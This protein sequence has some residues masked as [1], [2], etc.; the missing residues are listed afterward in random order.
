MTNGP[1]Q[2]TPFRILLVED[3]PADVDLTREALE[4]CRVAVEMTD[5]D[6]GHDALQFL[7]REGKYSGATM[8]D[9]ILLDLNLPGKNGRDVL[10][11]IG[12]D[13]QLRAIPVVILTSS[14]A[15]EDI[16]KAYD[17]GANCYIS[18]PVD[19]GE[20]QKIVEAIESFWLTLVKLPGKNCS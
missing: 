17:L 2:K 15:H 8:P 5:V 12:K 4:E 19:L 20:F 16:V 7:R 6:N 9:L 11:E 10:Y 18:K 13:S 1:A 3:N 14:A